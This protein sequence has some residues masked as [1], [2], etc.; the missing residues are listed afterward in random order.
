MEAPFLKQKDIFI[1]G[2]EGYH[3]YRI[4][5]AI[6]SAN[7]TILVFCE[8]RKHSQTDYGDIDIVLKRSFDNGRTWEPMQI[9]A[10]DGANT[11]GNPSPVVDRDTGTMW[12]LFCKNNIQ[13]FVTKSTK[14]KN[15]TG[16]QPAP[17]MAFSS[18]T[19]NL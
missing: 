15:G 1:S 13:V 18:K 9:V 19:A 11:I 10:D 4:P 3:T 8:G 14:K 6:V 17:V 16:M 2:K 12:L 7:G 5:A